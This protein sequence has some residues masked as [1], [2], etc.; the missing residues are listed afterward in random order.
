MITSVSPPHA[1][2]SELGIFPDNKLVRREI[3]VPPF[4]P[5]WGGEGGPGFGACEELAVGSEAAKKGETIKLSTSWGSLS[6]GRKGGGR[7]LR[8][9]AP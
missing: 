9:S 3:H 2:L 1:P 7:G 8:V 4:G 5:N 6:A